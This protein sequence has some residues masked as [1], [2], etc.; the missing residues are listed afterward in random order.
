M[1]LPRL[2]VVLVSPFTFGHLRKAVAHYRA[3][4][5]VSEIE[6]IL[7]APE[8]RALSDAEAGEWEG[9]HSVRVV[10]VGP[11]HS[12][13]LVAA[14]AIP[15]AQ[16][17]ILAYME[18]HVYVA[19]DWAEQ[20]LA[21][22]EGPWTAVA[23]Q[24]E[25]ANPRTVWSWVNL[26]VSFGW[27]AE[28]S[29]I[30]ECTEL[31][32]HNVS[33]RVAALRALSPLTGDEL[34]REGD[35]LARLRQAGARFALAEK[36]RGRHMNGATLAATWHIRFHAGRRYAVRRAEREGWSILWRT[37]Y[38]LGSPLFPFLRLYRFERELPGVLARAG[39]RIYAALWVGL[40]FDAVGQAAGYALGAADELQV[41]EDY[42]IHL[43]RYVTSEEAASMDL[44]APNFPATRPPE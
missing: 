33:F 5:V 31:P 10:P 39:R 30:G 20:L 44:P 24:L 21:A 2:T 8:E 22:Y 32:G 28:G 7:I 13:D 25:N 36:A 35:L 17:P 29:A 38:T 37:L 14:R 18:D 4:T 34:R 26:I 43:R 42:E 11:I 9:F 15:L 40:L 41:L 3:Q 6:L 19:P 23:T 1:M 16:A 27:W 12:V